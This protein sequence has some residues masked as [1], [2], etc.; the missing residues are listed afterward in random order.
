MDNLHAD[1]ISLSS[2][3]GAGEEAGTVPKDSAPDKVSHNPRCP[4]LFLDHT[5]YLA[6]DKFDPIW[7]ELDKRNCVVFL[8]G[9]QTPSSNTYPHPFLGVPITEAPHETFKAASHLVVTGK[10]RRYPNVRIILAHMGGTVPFLAPRVAVLSRHMGSPLTPEEIL[11]DFK[12]FYFD[13]A[14]SAYKT[15]FDAI[16]SFIG[17]NAHKQLLYGTDFPGVYILLI[18]LVTECRR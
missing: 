18:L 8:H 5:V 15:N 7:E 3:Y 10:K 13:V 16:K 14:L 12:T 4:S 1:G 11:E 2:S 17:E 9:T 6:D